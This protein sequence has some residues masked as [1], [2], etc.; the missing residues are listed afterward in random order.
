MRIP[1]PRKKGEGWLTRSVA[2]GALQVF[3]ALVEEFGAQECDFVVGG[4]GE[5]KATFSVRFFDAGAVGVGVGEGEVRGV[6]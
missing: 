3:N 4:R 2:L 5:V 6:A 1:T